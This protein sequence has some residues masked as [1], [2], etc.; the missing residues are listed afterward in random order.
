MNLGHAC[1]GTP[2]GQPA[3]SARYCPG[4]PPLSGASIASCFAVALSS[5]RPTRFWSESSMSGARFLNATAKFC[6][7]DGNRCNRS[8]SASIACDS[9]LPTR[10]SLQNSANR[11]VVGAGQI[12]SPRREVSHHVHAPVP[13]AHHNE[14][15][16]ANSGAQEATPILQPC[17]VALAASARRYQLAKIC[18][19]FVGRAQEGPFSVQGVSDCGPPTG[20]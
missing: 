7:P 6:S 17:R 16:A 20:A 19:V 3:L 9:R 2:I 10:S 13:S 5:A 1:R 15:A 14:G 18:S 4:E 11:E 8:T 12:G